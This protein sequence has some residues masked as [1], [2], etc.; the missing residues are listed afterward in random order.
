MPGSPGTF[1]LS[2]RTVRLHSIVSTVEHIPSHSGLILSMLTGAFDSS[3]AIF[4]LYSIIYHSSGRTFTA[5]QVLPLLSCCTPFHFPCPNLP[6]ACHVLQDRWRARQASRRRHG[7]DRRC[8]ARPSSLPRP[9][10]PAEPLLSK[11]AASDEKA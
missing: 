8:R 6:N 11:N 4:L 1:P 7:N 5:Q 9:T 2:R 3:S 10:L